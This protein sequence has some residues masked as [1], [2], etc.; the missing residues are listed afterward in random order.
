M[1]FQNRQFII[2]LPAPQSQ[3]YDL[4]PIVYYRNPYYYSY[5]PEYYT[6]LLYVWRA[7]LKMYAVMAK[8]KK[9]FLIERGLDRTVDALYKIERKDKGSYG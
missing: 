2:K 6:K 7:D 1:L 4:K 3:F 5:M 9:W 8:G